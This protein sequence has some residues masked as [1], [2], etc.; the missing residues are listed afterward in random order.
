[1]GTTRRAST[2]AS[3]R[4]KQRSDRGPSW[5]AVH[6]GGRRGD[7]DLYRAEVVAPARPRRA[8][9]RA[10]PTGW[11]TEFVGPSGA[12]RE[13]GSVVVRRGDGTRMKPAESQP[14]EEQHQRHGQTAKAVDD[15]CGKA[16]DVPAQPGELRA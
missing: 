5:R 1:M 15:E 14:Q 2:T 16:V 11:T 12:A 9:R 8:P 4:Q 7:T 3:V 6:D 10:A 13:F